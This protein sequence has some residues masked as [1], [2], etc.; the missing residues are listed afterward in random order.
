MPLTWQPSADGIRVKNGRRLNLTMIVGFPNPEVHRPM[1]EVVQ[2]QL[3]DVGIA[4]EIM[5]TADNAAYQ[6]RVQSGKEICGPRREDK[7]TP[8]PASFRI[9]CFTAGSRASRR[10]TPACSDRALALTA[11]SRRAERRW[12]RRRCK[13]APRKPCGC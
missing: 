6:A 2:A 7:T 1:P 11:S 3:K 4:L 12:S 8:I 10:G 9:S 13:G 5:Q